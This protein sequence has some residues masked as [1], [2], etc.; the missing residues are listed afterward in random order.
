[1]IEIYAKNMQT[2]L[3]LAMKGISKDVH[4]SIWTAKKDSFTNSIFLSVDSGEETHVVEAGKSDVEFKLSISSADLLLL[5]IL[6][7]RSQA[8]RTNIFLK[9]ADGC[10]NYKDSEYSVQIKDTEKD[11]CYTRKSFKPILLNSKNNVSAKAFCRY[12]RSLIKGIRIKKADMIQCLVYCIDSDNLE[13]LPYKMQFVS[14]DGSCTEVPFSD[15]QMISE[16]KKT[17]VYGFMMS[18]GKLL[19][20]ISLVQKEKQSEHFKLSFGQEALEITTNYKYHY[21]QMDSQL[22]KTETYNLDA[23][24]FKL[25]M[26]NKDSLLVLLKY[27][28]DMIEQDTV[29]FVFLRD[30]VYIEELN[31]GKIRTKI[32]CRCSNDNIIKDSFKI[33]V[34]HFITLLKNFPESELAIIAHN[35]GKVM[36][37]NS[38]I[39][40]I[41]KTED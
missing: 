39:Y 19:N 12:V 10:L 13:Q 29:N 18:A 24:G 14:S 25:S 41:M 17:T 38:K 23:N 33:D 22:T 21:I 26:T 4:I 28:S 11:Y 1:M 30:H 15:T 27:A 20:C 3:S 40:F 34:K 35:G 5:K 6:L 32:D 8:N 36:S 37:D 7:N 9:H 31:E 16:D 2:F